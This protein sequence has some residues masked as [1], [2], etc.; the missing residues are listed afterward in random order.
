MLVAYARVL[1]AGRQKLRK[2]LAIIEISS[3]K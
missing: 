1:P 3:G 2:I